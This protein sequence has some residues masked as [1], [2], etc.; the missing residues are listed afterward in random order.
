METLTFN[1]T[2]YTVDH[3]AK[4]TDYIHGYDADG[5]LVVAFDGV[6]DFSGFTYSGTYMTPS[7]C[8]A[9]VCNDVKFCGGHFKTRG[10]EDIYLM[11]ANHFGCYYRKVDGVIEWVNPP[12]ELGVEYR[13]T[14][15]H[16]GKVVYAKAVDCGNMPASATKY[17]AHGVISGATYVSVRL[18]FQYGDT[19]CEIVK[20]GDGDDVINISGANIKIVCPWSAGNYQACAFLKYVKD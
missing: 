8:L 4:G 6:T 18:V 19:A 20:G 10:G 17:V 1:G 3:A 16:N 2:Q 5:V 11:S 13:T 9:E 14:E 12:M 15:R 7:D